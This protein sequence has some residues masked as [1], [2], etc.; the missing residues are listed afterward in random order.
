M[1]RVLK[2]LLA[3]LIALMGLL[4][5][6]AAPSDLKV[7]VLIPEQVIRRVV[8]DPA[9]ETEI[10]RVLIASGFRVIDIKQS[11]VLQAREDMAAVLR[12]GSRQALVDLGLK[13]NADVLI[14][15][16]AFAEEIVPVPDEVRANGLRAYLARLEIKGIDL[17]TG[18]LFLSAAYTGSGIAAADFIA[19]K[20]A[21][22]KTA[23]KAAPEVAN[24][25]RDWEAGKTVADRAGAA[26]RHHR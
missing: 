25:L 10:Q 19:G 17:A 8:P 23:A 22:Q 26:A 4:T 20:T 1:T 21:L 11:E 7:L 18:Q 15:G 12:G 5:A 3:P 16:E 6:S 14:S 24:R 9:A 13:F 2:F